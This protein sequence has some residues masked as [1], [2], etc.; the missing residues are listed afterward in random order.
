M[1]FA[2]AGASTS[3]ALLPAEGA[4][5]PQRELLLL[6]ESSTEG[7]GEQPSSPCCPDAGAIVEVP[8]TDAGAFSE[9]SKKD[10]EKSTCEIVFV[11]LA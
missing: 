10:Q 9:L 3:S 7:D 4:A 8:G 1:G 11:S 6:P 2:A 5:P